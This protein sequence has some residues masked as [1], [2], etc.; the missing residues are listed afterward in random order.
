M[1]IL[2]T[3]KLKAVLFLAL[4]LALLALSARAWKHDTPRASGPPEEVE[5]PLPGVRLMY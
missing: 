1:R 4:L 2:T 5:S 3:R